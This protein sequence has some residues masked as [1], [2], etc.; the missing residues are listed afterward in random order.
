MSKTGRGKWAAPTPS[1]NGDDRP[2]VNPGPDDFP[3]IYITN[4]ASPARPRHPPAPLSGAGPRV[5][6]PAAENW[7]N[8]FQDVHTS[9]PRGCAYQRAIPFRSE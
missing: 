7:R 1:H 5:V 3:F 8:F 4:R 6:Y 2:R 9:L